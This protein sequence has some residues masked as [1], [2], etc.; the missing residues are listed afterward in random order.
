MFENEM[1]TRAAICGTGIL[2]GLVLL[3]AH[4]PVICL[5]VPVAI[6]FLGIVADPE[7]TH[8]VWYGMLN[9]L[10]IFELPELTDIER[11][12]YAEKRHYF[13]FGEVGMAAILAGVFAVPLGIFMAGRTEIP[14][15]FIGAAVLFLPLFV[16]LPKLIQQA[17]KADTDAAIEAFGKNEQV[18]KV[19][20]TL[21]ISMAGLV[22]AQ[23]L[24][25]ATAQ[26]IVS[27]I[28]GMG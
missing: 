6:L 3:L 24:D 8:A 12:T 15:A 20:W 14:L 22:L 4:L 1:Q 10:G 13:W 11:L 18:K 16:F 17:M 19:F 21:F 27:M 5:L 25:P 26:Q 9:A 23:V 2:L 28:T 7:E